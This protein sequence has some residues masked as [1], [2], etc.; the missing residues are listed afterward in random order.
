MTWEPGAK[1]SDTVRGVLPVVTPEEMRACDDAA[2]ER[3]VELIERAGRAVT[4]TAL[5]LLGGAY[6]R[7]V[8]VIAGKGSN[9]ADGRVAARRLGRAGVRVTVLDAAEVGTRTLPPCDLVVDAAYGT[10]FSGTWVPPEV[11]STP[12]L[13][14]D[15]PSGVDGL[16]GEAAGPVLRALTTVTFAAH[17]PGLLL[18]A[19]RGLAGDVEVADIGLDVSRALAHLVTDADVAGWLHD[20]GADAHKWRGAVWLV[21]G[22]PGMAGAAALATRGAQRA[23]AGYVR[24]STPGGA[25]G[26]AVPLE[27]VGTELPAWGWAG[28]VLAGVGRFEALAVGPGLGRAAGTAAEVRALVAGHG[29]VPIV[30][31]GDGLHALGES[32]H[33]G[34]GA[35]LTPHDGE[36]ERLVG[37]P[38]GADRLDAARALAS[39]TGAFVLLKGGTTVIAAPAGEVLLVTAGDARLAT[40][41]TGDVLTGIVA[42]LLASGLAPLQAAAAAAHIHGRAGSLGWRRG[43]VAGD[44]PDLVPVVLD[45]LPRS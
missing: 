12:V 31:D 19:G 25:P 41:G 22:S 33:V 7:R 1:R 44:L 38:P 26:D 36:Y 42:A 18:G 23:G 16:T 30:V 5:R 45:G 11:G 2:P 15:L 32:P 40:A 24:V 14:V 8:V 6:G 43:L 21:A 17:K 35:V 27:A 37:R 9:G 10:G 20:R 39:S 34:A 13:A 28:E 4:R 3:A 29:D